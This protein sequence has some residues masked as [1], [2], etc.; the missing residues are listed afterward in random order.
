MVAHILQASR[1]SATK[2]RIMRT[3]FISHKLLQKYLGYVVE[4]G[5]LFCDSS[6][7]VYRIT[8][9]GIQYLDYFEQC[10][11]TENELVNKKKLIFEILQENS[12]EFMSDLLRPK[13]I[14]HSVA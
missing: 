5:L 13:S 12:G 9:K 1:D 4:S 3:C 8:S 11:H 6:S 7:K 10:R 14:P 2:T